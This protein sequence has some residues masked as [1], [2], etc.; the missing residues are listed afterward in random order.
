LS[1]V[2]AASF[3]CKIPLYHVVGY[4][5][6]SSSSRYRMC[7]WLWGGL[8]LINFFPSSFLFP[9]PKTTGY[10]FLI[11]IFQL[12]SLF[13]WFLISL[14]GFFVSILMFLIPSFNLSLWFIVYSNLV[15]IFCI[16]FVLLLDLFFF[17]F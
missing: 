2:C 11:L 4:D 10:S 16:F 12:Q 6:A 13:F 17:S 1:N 15:L 7:R 3:W 14:I 5:D 8:S 9:T